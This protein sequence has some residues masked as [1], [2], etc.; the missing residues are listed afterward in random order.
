VR[1]TEH[2]LEAAGE[3]APALR[4]ATTDGD[5]PVVLLLHGLG[6]R[7][8]VFSPVIMRMAER[9]RFVAV[10][11]RGHGASAR[12]PGRYAI[13]DFARDARRVVEEV[14]GPPALVYGHSLGGWVALALAAE[15]PDLVRAVLVGDTAI[16]PRDL[17]PE[18]AVSYLADLPIALRSLAKS[19]QQ[20][21][22]D[23]LEHLRDG[24]LTDDFHPEEVL[25]RVT[26]PVLL[27]QGDPACGGLMRDSDVSRALELLPSARHERFDG[28]GHGLHVEDAERLLEAV[29]PFLEEAVAEPPG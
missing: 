9:W 5:G 29:V 18:F 1:P 14:V 23:V 7:W 8:Q 11:L 15:H 4:Y 19:L 24:R 20:L 6:A 26:C 13:A 27:L 3:D 22:P 10:D 2:L 12:A 25:P 21:D 28:I 17:D 16:F